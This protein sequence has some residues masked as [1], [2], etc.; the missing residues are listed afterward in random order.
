ME[1]ASLSEAFIDPSVSYEQDQMSEIL[2]EIP[3]PPQEQNSVAQTSCM[4]S[5]SHVSNC[6]YCS[7][8][9]AIRGNNLTIIIMLVILIWFLF[10]K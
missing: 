3:Q 2:D 6:M 7:G 9:H 8:K 1:Y 5:E 10:K 4:A